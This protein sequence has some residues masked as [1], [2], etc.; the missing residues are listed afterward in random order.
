MPVLVYGRFGLPRSLGPFVPTL[1]PVSKHNLE[2]NVSSRG[3]YPENAP[4]RSAG[5]SPAG[6]PGVS[7]DNAP[8]PGGET[9]P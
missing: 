4:A 3:A 5:V 2:G 1:A 8:N 9:P 7:P 6:L